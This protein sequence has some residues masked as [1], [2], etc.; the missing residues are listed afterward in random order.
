MEELTVEPG[1]SIVASFVLTPSSSSF[2]SSSSSS[3]SSDDDDDDIQAMDTALLVQTKDLSLQTNS[4][5]DRPHQCDIC[6]GHFTKFSTLVKHRNA[7]RDQDGPSHF[8]CKNCA[9]VLKTFIQR[10]QHEKIHR[11]REER[12]KILCP[13][14]GCNKQF[15]ARNLPRHLPV[16][17][18]V[19]PFECVKC[20]Q[21]FKANRELQIH[22]KRF[23]IIQPQNS[24]DSVACEHST[25]QFI[26]QPFWER[27]TELFHSNVRENSSFSCPECLDVYN[28]RISL[29]QHIFLE[30]YSEAI[31]LSD[32]RHLER[33]TENLLSS[34][35]A[36]SEEES[37]EKLLLWYYFKTN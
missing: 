3:S 11:P 21:K 14:P 13:F 22:I 20:D 33:S 36:M 4:N 24:I 15:L 34:H 30:H 37:W 31:Q 1:R 25:K 6:E 12:P 28:S 16:H 23:H 35:E 27:H 32:P 7:H 2:S 17:S 29:R 5:D 18:D 9:R 10:S 26:S 19:R 8:P